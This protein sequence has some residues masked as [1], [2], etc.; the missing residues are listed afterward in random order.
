MASVSTDTPTGSSSS[1]N[2]GDDIFSGFLSASAVSG[3]SATTGQASI[4][5]E[6]PK[7]DTVG[8]SADSKRSAEENSFFNQPA[9][10]AQEKKQL[11]KDSILALYSSVPA[12]GTTPAQAPASQPFGGAFCCSTN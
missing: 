2:K 8:N 12:S 7:N 5:S 1:P 10:S 4:P 9:A 3:S 6:P 11:T